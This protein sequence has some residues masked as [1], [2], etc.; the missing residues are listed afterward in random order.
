MAPS[1]CVIRTETWQSPPR[2]SWTRAGSPTCPPEQPGD[3]VTATRNW[4]P[5]HSHRRAR[6]VLL[7]AAVRGVCAGVVRALLD[8]LLDQ[9]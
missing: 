7:A 2:P 8:H 4:D 3:L 6:L 9:H 5:R 1:L